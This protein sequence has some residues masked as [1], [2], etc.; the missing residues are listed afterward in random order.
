MAIPERET[1]LLPLGSEPDPSN[2]DK[3][4]PR[5]VVMREPN[6]AQWY[7]VTRMPSQLERGHTTDAMLTFGDLLE[8]LMVQQEDISY[9]HRGLVNGTIELSEY[10]E[11]LLELMR[12]FGKDQVDEPAPRTGPRPAAKRATRARR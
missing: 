1:V 6:E 4:R 5:Q 12:H 2:P 10:L 9:A 11:L 7:V 3:R 8:A